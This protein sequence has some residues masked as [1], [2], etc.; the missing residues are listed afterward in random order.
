MNACSVCICFEIVILY[1]IFLCIFPNT[2]LKFLLQVLHI[3]FFFCFSFTP[4]AIVRFNLKLRITVCL[5]F[6]FVILHSIF[7]LCFLK[8]KIKV[9]ASSSVYIYTDE[10]RSNK[11][12][13]LQR[14]NNYFYL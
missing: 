1:S 7:S 10:M 9:S 3:F 13:Q 11:M 8:P 4:S 12:L 2:K 6:E 5:C 14:N